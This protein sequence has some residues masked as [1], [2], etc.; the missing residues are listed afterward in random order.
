MVDWNASCKKK[1]PPVIAMTTVFIMNG[2]I[3]KVLL[4]YWGHRKKS[5]PLADMS[6]EGVLGGSYN[7]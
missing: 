4:L 1:C 6:W 3:I 2:R 7:R 5:R